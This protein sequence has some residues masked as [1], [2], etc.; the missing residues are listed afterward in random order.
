MVKKFQENIFHFNLFERG[1]RIVV[2]VSGGPDSVCLLSLLNSIK[3]KYDLSIVVAHVNYDLRGKDSEKDAEFVKN[4]AEE[5]S[6]PFEIYRAAGRKLPAENTEENLRI[7]RYEFFEKVRKKHGADYIAIGHNLNDQA[8][9]VLM[10]LIRGAGLRGLSAIKFKNGNIVRPLLNISRTEIIEYLKT[11]KIHYRIDKSNLGTDFT[12]NKIRNQL[13]P[14]IEK[15]L[16]PNIQELL[17][18]L[19]QS[20]ADDY[21]FINSFAKEWLRIKRDISVSELASFHPAIQREILRI[22]IEELKPNLRR[23]EFA[24]IDEII[25]MIKSS[26]NKQQYIILKGLKIARKGDRL[27]IENT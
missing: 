6:L 14:F 15:K 18:K 12:R 8:E 1:S 13:I 7:I 2:G 27:T 21:A 4:L 25:K 26:K 9:T 10:R 19:S 24:H 23:I 3:G 22:R 20:I 16:N 5:C 17:Y 11:K